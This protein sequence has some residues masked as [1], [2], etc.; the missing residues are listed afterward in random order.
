MSRLRIKL[1]DFELDYEGTD[2]FI[3][4]QLPGLLKSIHEIEPKI[5]K[6]SPAKGAAGN[7]DKSSPAFHSE[8]STNTIAQ[9]LEAKTGPELAKAAAARL[10]LVLKKATFTKK[11]NLAEMR[12]ATNFFKKSHQN[13]ADKILKS[14]TDDGTLLLQASG[15][16]AFADASRIAMEEKLAEV[17]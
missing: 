14:V 12:S 17:G 4:D 10:A 1:G 13:N 5:A 6:A 2:E 16:Y 11:D 8:T 9:K 15:S 3:K 7:G